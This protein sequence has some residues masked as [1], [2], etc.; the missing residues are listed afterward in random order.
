V[1]IDF[2]SLDATAQSK[3]QSAVSNVKVRLG[4]VLTESMLNDV[5]DSML[6]DAII[7]ITKT[8]SSLPE[9]APQ[10][11]AAFKNLYAGLVKFKGEKED[12]IALK[13]TTAETSKPALATLDDDGNL[14]IDLNNLNAILTGDDT[15]FEQFISLLVDFRNGL[16]ADI[17]TNGKSAVSVVSDMIAGRVNAQSKSGNLT[18]NKWGETYAV[19]GDEAKEVADLLAALIMSDIDA[20]KMS[21]AWADF[22]AHGYQSVAFSV[23]VGAGNFADAL[24]AANVETAADKLEGGQLRV[25]FKVAQNIKADS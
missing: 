19:K 25:G 23:G 14:V 6:D 9:G 1:D 12:F 8:I 10:T 24:K 16:G 7:T 20:T 5:I 4:D 15:T 21:E 13:T 22:E 17:E 18:V 11:A 2:S 3:L